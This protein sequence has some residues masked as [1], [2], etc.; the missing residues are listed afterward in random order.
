MRSAHQ[1]SSSP[2]DICPALSLFQFSVAAEQGLK[3]MEDREGIR[4]VRAVLQGMMNYGIG[5]DTCGDEKR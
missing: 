5:F 4:A 1:P 2:H 3:D